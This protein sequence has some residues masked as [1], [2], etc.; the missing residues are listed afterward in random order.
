MPAPA[1]KKLF[2]EILRTS[3]D[4]AVVQYRSVERES[5]VVRHGLDKHLQP[6]TDVSRAATEL[7]RSRLFSHVGFYRVVH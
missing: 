4:G 2:Q 1:Q 6:M 3:R 5:L 7:D